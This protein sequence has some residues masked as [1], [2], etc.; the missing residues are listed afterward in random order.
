MASLTVSLSPLVSSFLSS[1]SLFHTISPSST[2]SSVRSISTGL[3][4]GLC[5]WSGYLLLALVKALTHTGVPDSHSC[6]HHE[7]AEVTSEH[8]LTILHYWQSPVHLQYC[9]TCILIVIIPMQ[10][11]FLRECARVLVHMIVHELHPYEWAILIRR[12]L[13]HLWMSSGT[14][15]VW[16]G[17]GGRN[18][19]WGRRQRAIC[20]IFC[21][22]CTVNES[23]AEFRLSYELY[24]THKSQISLTNNCLRKKWRV[25]VWR[26]SVQFDIHIIVQIFKKKS[27]STTCITRPSPCTGLG[28]ACKV[29]LC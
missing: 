8:R 27:A 15:T 19:M 25:L 16:G 24:N 18:A 9:Q 6:V 13:I 2:L 3:L 21:A 23:S 11:L 10:Q 7:P 26:T 22:K 12:D 5:D 17:G 29:P 20:N 14:N 28:C 1:L 4:T